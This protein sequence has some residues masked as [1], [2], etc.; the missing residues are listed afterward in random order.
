MRVG[1]VLE[2]ENGV[3]GNVCS[4]FGQCKYFLLAVVDPDNKRVVGSRI[5]P[6]AAV[7]GGG[8]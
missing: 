4:H 8:G 2:D 5:V 6:N 7:H 1:V 3:H